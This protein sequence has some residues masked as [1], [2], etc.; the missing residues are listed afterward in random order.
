MIIG[1]GIDLVEVTRF[2]GWHNYQTLRLQKV[3]SLEEI[4]YCRAQSSLSPERFAA[5]FAAKEALYKALA[6]HSLPGRPIPFLTLCKNSSVVSTP[7]GPQLQVNWAALTPFYPHIAQP[8]F[9]LSLTHTKTTACAVV[10]AQA[11]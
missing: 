2:Q 11:T 5:R 3:F 9:M 6:P 1:L 7:I 8:K 4:A 10:V